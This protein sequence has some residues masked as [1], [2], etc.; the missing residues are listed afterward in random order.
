MDFLKAEKNEM[1]II[2]SLYKGAIGTMGCTW[3]E[4]YPAMEHTLGDIQRGDLFCLKDES[5]TIIGAISIDDDKEVEAL[6]CW[7]KN[8]A[9]LSRLVVAEKCQNQ[10][11]A[12]Y[13]LRK[14]MEVLKQRGYE[15]VHFLVS[16]DHVKALKAYEKLEFNSVGESDLYGGNWWC[17]EKKL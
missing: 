5:G 1:E 16:K 2:R 3:S 6:T 12:G 9:E 11:L 14:S 7:S 15:Y 13:M 4:E 17:Y 8:G 10:G